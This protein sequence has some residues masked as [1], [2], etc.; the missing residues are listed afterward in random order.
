MRRSLPGQERLVS[1]C[2]VVVVLTLGARDGAAQQAASTGPPLAGARSVAPVPA[3]KM[4]AFRPAAGSVVVLGYDELRSLG[5]VSPL[6]L[7]KC[8][9]LEGPVCEALWHDISIGFILTLPGGAS[10]I[11]WRAFPVMP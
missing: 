1:L 3:T 7:A 2:L 5:G 4:D 9:T 11:A 6:M 10:R 8:A